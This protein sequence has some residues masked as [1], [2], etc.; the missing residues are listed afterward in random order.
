MANPT[1]NR[2]KTRRHPLR[3]RL[4]AV[5]TGTAVKTLRVL[6][7]RTALNLAAKLG[8]RVAAFD[9]P[10]RRFARANLKLVFPDWDEARRETF[11]RSSFSELGR[12]MAEW[13]RLPD[14]SPTEVLARVDFQ[15]ME[16]LEQALAQGRGVLVITAHYGSWELLLRAAGVALADHEVTAVGREQRN[17]YFQAMIDQ[18]RSLSG[19]RPLP[20]DAR[21]ILRA[22]QRN[23]VIGILADHYLSE[24][25]G[26]LL[27]PFLGKAAWSNPGPATLALRTGC[28]LL[29]AHTHRISENRHRVELEAGPQP[30]TGKDRQQNIAEFTA[31]INEAIGRV[32]QH[33]PV[34]W[35]WANRRWRSSPAVEQGFYDAR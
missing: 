9:T 18:R 1:G 33:Q 7:E 13:A 6:P 16:L 2:R 5:A 12:S 3:W 35:L 15:G 25:K 29:L 27:A 31:K 14:L 20:Q 28:P 17:P 24:R 23:A 32:I 21:S 8:R 4:E 34:H 10:A 19:W 30:P 26:G 22:L 11:L